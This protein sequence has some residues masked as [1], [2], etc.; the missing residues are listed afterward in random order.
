MPSGTPAS[1][2]GLSAG[3]TITAVNGQSVSSPSGLTKVM[4][5]Q[6][7]GDKVS[8]TYTDTNG[9]SQTAQVT[10]ASGPPQ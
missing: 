5:Q 2:A 10:L 7:P 4:L 3:D 1:A 6:K 9:N 8:V